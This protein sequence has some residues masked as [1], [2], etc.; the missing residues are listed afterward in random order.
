VGGIAT[1]GFSDKNMSI[2]HFQNV[3][4]E[5]IIIILMV[6]GA[7]NFAL[8]YGFYQKGIRAYTTS[9][10]FRF[11]ILVMVV[12]T[13]VVT[14]SLNGTVYATAAESLRYAAFQVVSVT[15]TT[16]YSTADFG[17]WPS[18]SQILLLVLMFFG[19]SVGSTTGSIKCVR[20]LL[21]I[22]LGYKEIYRLIHPHAV[23]TVKLGGKVVPPEI[24]R[25]V[26][27][28]T[29]LFISVFVVSAA[30]LSGLGLDPLTAISS[31]AATLGNV[32]PALGELGPA[33]NYSMVP[34]AGKWVLVFNMLLGRL[35]I[36][37]LLIL[38]VPAFWKG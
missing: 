4:V 32:G 9:E 30:V 5:G 1:G 20:L 12:A 14:L 18:F 36:Y 19:G 29:F 38:L 21:L 24:M 23:I 7:T 33:S 10:E 34:D 27:G 8:H 13:I 17:S 37:T 35:E 6:L 11:Y 25:G 2:A 3:Y 28:F 26:A 22:K 31:A 15:T 16:G